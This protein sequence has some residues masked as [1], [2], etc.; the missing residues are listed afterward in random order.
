[1]QR[2]HPATPGS[3]SLYLVIGALICVAALVGVLVVASRVGNTFGGNSLS[4]PRLLPSLP[5]GTRKT[6]TLPPHTWRGTCPTCHVSIRN[7]NPWD[8]SGQAQGKFVKVEQ[9]AAAPPV[10]ITPPLNSQ[11]SPFPWCTAVPA[12]ATV[13]VPN[14]QAAALPQGGALRDI[15]SPVE[16]NAAGKA[17]FEGHWLGMELMD[18]T[19]SLRRIYKIPDNV[20]GV[21]V[22]EVTLES[23]E[24]GI[25][26]GDVV[27]AI[28]GWRT[29]VL[30]EFFQATMRVND[31]RK[32][33]V[34]VCRLGS[35]QRFTLVAKNSPTLGFAQMEAA[36]PIKPGAV[37]PHKNRRE[38]CTACHVFMATGGQLPTDAGDI[39]PSPPP[40]NANARAP[41]AY[42]GACNTC[43]QIIR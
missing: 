18:L 41:H 37:S 20:A 27:V 10:G 4:T 15:L 22:D 30:T 34:M 39:L 7:L 29:G 5:A 26:A 12:A 35:E 11:T 16:Q 19:P 36:A 32:A 40:I 13:P 42:R 21:I 3:G 43:H 14:Q 17:L 23:A 2:A 31:E 9:A 6:V 24:S 28:N 8:P 33:E 38:A 1:M 25:L